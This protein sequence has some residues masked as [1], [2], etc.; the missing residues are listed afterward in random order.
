MG[1]QER[2]LAYADAF[3]ESYEDDDWSHVE[4]YFTEQ[5]VYEG[6]PDARGRAA[7]LAKLKNGVDSFDRLM[8]SRTPDFQTPAVDGDTLTMRWK[9]TYTKAG[10]PDLVISG[11]ETAIFDGDRIALLRDTFDPEAQKGMGEWMTQHGAALR[12]S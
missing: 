12:G 1:I 6:D 10:C 9:V 4:P 8:D 5:A 2:Y 7:V 3:E 11:V